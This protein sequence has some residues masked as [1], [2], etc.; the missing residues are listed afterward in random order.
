MMS[1]KSYLHNQTLS[2]TWLQTLLWRNSSP[3]NKNTV[4]IYSPLLCMSFFLLLNTKED[5]FLVTVD[6]NSKPPTFIV[7]FFPYYGSQWQL[8]TV[9][10]PTYF[11]TSFFV[12]VCVCSTEKKNR[13]GTNGG[14]VNGEFY[15]VN[16][17]FKHS[18]FHRMHRQVLWF[19]YKILIE[20][21]KICMVFFG[22]QPLHLARKSKSP[23]ERSPSKSGLC[24]LL[25]SQGS[26]SA[27]S[28]G[29]AGE[30]H[31]D[32]HVA[33]HQLIQWSL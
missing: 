15:F 4:I 31:P 9:W 10:S 26:A 20:T 3:T 18:V 22:G 12:S 14:C 19:H 33:H 17:S 6:S 29:T 24:R 27:F 28:L 2:P 16:Y 25:C 32:E 30:T 23:P 7:F 8:L 1:Q 13:F 5:T 11:K 21:S